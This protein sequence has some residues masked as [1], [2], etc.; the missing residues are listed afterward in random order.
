MADEEQEVENAEEA[1]EDAGEEEVGGKRR[2]S[3]KMLVLMIAVPVL[4]LGG[5][6]AFW[7]LDPF[8]GSSGDMA[9]VEE[10][11]PSVF[12]DMPDMLVNLSNVDS[13]NQYLKLQVA[14]EMSDEE[15]RDVIEPMM[16][17]I[18]DIFQIYLRELRSEDLHGSA[19]V[20]RLK[21]EL[22]RRINLVISPRRIDDVL[23]REM[24][25]Q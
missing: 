6:A 16:P 10:I 15:V 20:Y 13:R 19:G 2:L 23:F 12:F 14:L 8:G 22:L 3:G 9:E 17:R 5:G 25:V 21:E 24:L 18:M 11:T 7:F 1:E 4:L